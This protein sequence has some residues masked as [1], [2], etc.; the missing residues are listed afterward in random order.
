MARLSF[1]AVFNAIAF[2]STI[3]FILNV[4][5]PR[6][7]L[8][9][10]LR[11]VIEDSSNRNTSAVETALKGYS[12]KRESHIDRMS[13]LLIAA[14]P[15][16]T[17]RL[18]SVWSFLE[19]FVDKRIHTIVVAAPDWA[20]DE[21]ILEPFLRHASETIPHLEH[22]DIVI[23]YYV[24]DRYD[25]GLWCD[26]LKDEN[27]KIFNDHDDFILVND[28]ILAIHHYMGVLDL[29][30]TKKLA[31]TSLTYSNRPDYWL[32]SFY[33]GFS[34]KG[35][36]R[37]M[38]HACK[39]ADHP[40]WCRDTNEIIQ[41]RCIVDHFEID[42]ARLFPRQ[43]TAGIYSADVPDEMV[44][45]EKWQRETMWHFHWPYWYNQLHKVVSFPIMKTSNPNFIKRAHKWGVKVEACAS[46]LDPSFLAPMT[47]KDDRLVKISNLIFPDP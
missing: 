38:Q 37:Y 14:Y 28:S 44:K 19:C 3:G 8:S 5:L 9:I 32:E 33:R 43:V 11:S 7:S 12:Q 39:P 10:S 30:Q 36:K 46:H 26:S 4:W 16:D 31:L 15:V 29:L 34:K 20:K 27:Y 23:K 47:E 13:T 24:N 18:V 25:V 1:K 6:V 2:F 17:D 35:M 22:T 45:E 21:N 41:K 40:Y 42:V